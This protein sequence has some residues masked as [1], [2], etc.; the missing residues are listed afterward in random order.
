V[1]ACI[2]RA[3]VEERKQFVALAI[4]EGREPEHHRRAAVLAHF[5][6]KRLE[7]ATL[8]GR[9]QVGAVAQRDTAQ[10]LERAPDAKPHRIRLRRQRDH[11]DRPHC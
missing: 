7:Q 9:Q 11:Q 6:G 4:I 8:R 10:G 1:P 3:T 2:G 5:G